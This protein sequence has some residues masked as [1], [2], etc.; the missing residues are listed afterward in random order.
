MKNIF[1]KSIFFLLSICAS[2][3]LR[4][5]IKFERV[6]GGTGYD[7]GNSVI[8]TYN[9]GYAVV[10]S[11]TS[12][13]SG[14]TDMYLLIT[15]S[16][17]VALDQK[18]YGGINV[19]QGFS[20]KETSDSGLV[21]AGYTNSFGHGGYDMYVIKTDKNYNTVWTK[22]YGGPDWDFAY[23]IEQTPSDGGYI[24]AGSTYSY[25]SGN[26][27]M[28]LVKINSFGDTLWTRTYG[29]AGDDEARSVKPTIDGGYILT[30]NTKSFGDPNG[31]MFIVK[32]DMNGDTAWTHKY[33]G[34]LD[35][36]SYDVIQSNS[37]TEYIIG[38]ETKTASLG[39]QGAI[40]KL[41]ISGTQ[42][43]F[44]SIYGSTAD[45]GI[46]A[47][48]QTADG[49]FVTMG[50]TNSYG[51]GL[52]DFAFY[53][54]KPIG[55]FV[56]SKTY[57]GTKIDKGYCIKGTNDGGFIICGTALSYSTFEH[58]YLIKT[59]S[60]GSSSG[61]VINTVTGIN[62]PNIKTN[63]TFLAYPNPANDLVSVQISS[64]DFLN[65]KSIK[66]SIND[67]LGRICAEKIVS[68]ISSEP[69]TINT[70]EII[71]GVY[72]ISIESENYFSNQKLIIQKQ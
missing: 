34:P 71:S 9:S 29:G 60:T 38:G 8:Q 33:Q 20:V 64:K 5:Q 67:V 2:N 56:G 28:F 68:T 25:G 70:S 54:E 16:M 48:T 19:D 58:I 62:S 39:F 24:I 35:D 72:F 18:T 11:T 51:A 43:G 36:N 27:D 7:Y 3:L 22:T 61:T 46:R 1:I 13:G 53:I 66:I 57:G 31:D 12:F 32:T 17:G 44:T 42:T 14:N 63:N 40:L 49:R 50:Y 65:S 6:F 52:S 59:D 47:I 21:I 45:D 41:D 23:S 69:I 10:G 55:T 15:N 30:G 4:A 37:G 26:E